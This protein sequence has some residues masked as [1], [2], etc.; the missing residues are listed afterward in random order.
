MITAKML[1]RRFLLEVWKNGAVTI[2]ERGE[3]ATGGIPVYSTTRRG[4]AEMI[5]AY[6]CRLSR[7]DNETYH[8]NEFDRTIEDLD[9][10]AD[11]FEL[12][13][14][15]LRQAERRCAVAR[16]TLVAAGGPDV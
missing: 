6:H 14:L 3:P 7:L 2:R 11:L 9:R 4:D 12:S 5:R 13:H 8:L 1:S 16:G 15:R 10:V